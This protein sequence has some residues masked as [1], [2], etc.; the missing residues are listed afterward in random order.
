M[1]TI[2]NNCVEVLPSL[3]DHTKDQT[4]R[5]AWRDTKKMGVTTGRMIQEAKEPRFKVG[6][7]VRLY[8]KQR[9]KYKYFCKE[10]GVGIGIY[11]KEEVS[12]MDL[13]SKKP[14]DKNLF[15]INCLCP[16]KYTY[17]DNTLFFHKILGEGKITEVFE[18]S[19]VK[20]CTE[21][22]HFQVSRNGTDWTGLKYPLLKD[23]AKRDG[24]SDV[25]SIFKFF[26]E[27]YDLSTP[28]IFFVY[29]WKWKTE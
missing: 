13:Y 26:D 15:A 12:D 25:E 21:L 28:R 1:K 5:Q 3:L 20:Y 16:A 6:E 8:W 7:E 14:L 24:F 22:N 27:A 11:Q 17:F 9:G 10:C 18:I 29:R 23:L 19:M 2:N 4:I